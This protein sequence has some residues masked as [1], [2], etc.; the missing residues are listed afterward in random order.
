MK[1]RLNQDE[2]ENGIAIDARMDMQ[3]AANRLSDTWNKV[4]DAS[5]GHACIDALVKGIDSNGHHITFSQ[6][7][8]MEGSLI[9]TKGDN[10]VRYRLGGSKF[11]KHNIYLN[12]NETL[13][14][15]TGGVMRIDRLNGRPINLSNP[16]VVEHT[17]EEP[18]NSLAKLFSRG[19]RQTA[20]TI[21][22]TYLPDD[23][24]IA[25][26]TNTARF[27]QEA[28]DAAADAV[29]QFAGNAE[30]AERRAA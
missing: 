22:R 24:A 8:N 27:M 26:Y 25:D 16:N 9:I 4:L 2:S 30:K 19:K 14:L 5:N 18:R 1:N 28:L 13:A 12:G 15:E 6:E 7:Y 29:E 10:V 11:G 23:V 17:T 21:E 20:P 3:R